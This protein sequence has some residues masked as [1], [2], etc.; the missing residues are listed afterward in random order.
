MARPSLPEKCADLKNK[1][2]KNC[3]RKKCVCNIKNTLIA[4]MK[5]AYAYSSS[6][7]SGSCD[8][9]AYVSCKFKLFDTK[10]TPENVKRRHGGDK[11]YQHAGFGY[12]GQQREDL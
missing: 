10:C 9:C 12:H 8:T 3:C 6:S 5:M 7:S 11:S 4:I 1:N 2:R